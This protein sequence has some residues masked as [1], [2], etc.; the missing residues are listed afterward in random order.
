MSKFKIFI[1]ALCFIP[2]CLWGQTKSGD[3]EE[4]QIKGQV[5]DSLSKAC[6]P[7]VTIAV[8]PLEKTKHPV[9]LFA[10]DGNGNFNA[11]LNSPGYYLVSFRMVGMKTVN[12]QIHFSDSNKLID[13]GKVLLSN[14]D[15]KLQEIAVAGHKS[16]VQVNI[17][18]IIYH[19]SEDPDSKT[20]N[21]FE[22][23]QKVPLI[24]VTGD[25]EIK[26]KASSEFKILI[27]GRPSSLFSHNPNLVLKN[28]QAN[29]VKNIE[30]TTNPGPK[31]DAEGIG[32]IINIVTVKSK[33]EGYDAS[34]NASA[35]TTKANAY[36]TYLMTK[37]GKL[38][39]SGNYGYS[40][41]KSPQSNSRFYREDLK[42]DQ[43]KYLSQDGN[44]KDL[45][46]SQTGGGEGSYEIDSLNLVSIS[47]YTNHSKYSSN[48]FLEETLEDVNKTLAYSFDR[49][50]NSKTNSNSSDL[51]L[52]YQHSFKKNGELL[53]FSYRFSSSPNNGDNYTTISN[54]IN[55]N[56]I[57]KKDH[58]K[59]S[60]DEQTFQLDYVNPLTKIHNIETGIKYILRNNN[61]H[62]NYYQ[63]DPFMNE[64]IPLPS[65]AD[66]F[67]YTQNI[68]AGY[69]GYSLTWKKLGFKAGGRIEQVHE[70]VKLFSNEQPDYGT[71]NT[72]CTPSSSLSY[73][74]SDTKNIGLNYYLRIQRPGIWFLNP[75]V[76]NS[77]P[78]NISYGNPNL[79]SE[80]C[81]GFYIS[82]S[83]FT[84]KIN[85]LTYLSYRF[86]NNS[87]EPYTFIDEKG[88]TNNTYRNIGKAQN[89]G[90][91]ID[92]RWTAS[93]KL[94]FIANASS[95]Y[96]VMRS[97]D[98]ALKSNGLNSYIGQSIRYSFPNNLRV[99]L[100]GTYNSTSVGLQGKS[101]PNYSTSI[102]L[103]KDFLKEKLS[104]ST[105]VNNV[106]WKN[107]SSWNTTKDSSFY[108]H[109]NNKTIGRMINIDISYHFGK[110]EKSVKKAERGI[111][112]DDVKSK[113]NKGK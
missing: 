41:N 87:I 79:S 89:P 54:T 90:I 62:S 21:L 8:A 26:L 33:F 96:V 15:N 84:Q 3:A 81:N 92:F 52:D 70:Q 111:N 100:S 61:S 24:T 74:L 106:F 34:L 35:S 12:R 103:N 16:L 91:F 73:Q 14:S 53:T 95:D 56:P 49:H 85:L 58:N 67:D 83:S 30:V 43:Y 13:F 63:I 110:L 32:G 93:S 5:I 72:D 65:F 109:T 31:Y 78:H 102:Q 1:L 37:T 69:L 60:S 48:S 40:W 64:W 80:R 23:L 82:Y 7:Y 27:N 29:M 98:G 20:S 57:T 36:S 55:Y 88:V 99:R 75:Y 59:A 2:L 22:I 113:D 4:Y 46:H 17:D 39:F 47:F 6:I 107:K 50:N 68:F 97:R 51:N 101:S 112:N 42:S 66:N 44:T 18:K 71:K 77:D 10:S 45:G 104:I 108:I 94:V 105:R 11:R 76:D 28:M 9:K 19:V 86:M 38:S 25:D